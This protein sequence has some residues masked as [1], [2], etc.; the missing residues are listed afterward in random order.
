MSW[1]VRYIDRTLKHEMLSPELES[2]EEAFETAWTLAQDESNEI[3]A[4]EGPDEQTVTIEE[5]NAW[6]DR[7]SEQTSV[8]SEKPAAGID[9]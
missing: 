2:R 6:F 3:T 7:Q 5:I 8:A 4:L 9:E 1:H